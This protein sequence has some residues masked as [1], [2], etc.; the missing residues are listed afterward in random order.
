VFRRSINDQPIGEGNGRQ[1]PKRKVDEK[2]M[3]LLQFTPVPNCVI[4]DLASHLNKKASRKS[5]DPASFM[6]SQQSR[7]E[8]LHFDFDKAQEFYAVQDEFC[9]SKPKGF[10]SDKIL[11]QNKMYGVCLERRNPE[12]Y[13][14]FDIDTQREQEYMGEDDDGYQFDQICAKPAYMQRESEDQ[15]LEIT[16]GEK[17]KDLFEAEKSFGDIIM[18]E[19]LSE[20]EGKEEDMMMN[21]Q[22]ELLIEQLIS[23]MGVA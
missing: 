10:H 12:T 21:T 14:R 15:E 19:E 7:E 2:R 1:T 23:P 11:R 3:S 9:L 8:L 5:E 18:E 22:D 6:S 4:V 17:G 13:K 20:E 16:F